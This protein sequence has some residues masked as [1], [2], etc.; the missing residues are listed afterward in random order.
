MLDFLHIENVAVIKKLDIEFG[1]GFNVLTGET[2]AGKSIIIDSINMLLGA[3]ATKEIIRHGEQ[4]AVVSAFFSNVSDDI[5]KLCDEYDIP[6]DREDAFSIYRSF[7][8]DGKNAVKINSYPATLTQ[9]RAIG[10]HLINIHGQNENQSFMNKSNHIRLLDEYADSE[11]LLL[12]YGALYSKLNSIKAEIGALIEENKQKDTMIDILNFQIKEISAAKLKDIN[13]E[14]KLVELRN[15]LKGAEKIIKGSQTVYK[16]LMQNESGISASV[17][18]TKAIDA[19]NKLSDVEGDAS[20]LCERLTGIKFEIEDIAERAK[21]YSSFEGVGDPQH[22]L[23]IVEDRLAVIQRLERKYGPDIE[24]VINF[25]NDAE[26]KL[27]NFENAENQILDLKDEYKK[28]YSSALDIAKNIHSNRQRFSV[29]LSKLVKEA[30]EFLDMPKVKFEI[31]VEELQKE[32]NPVLNS[33]GCDDVEFLIATNAGEESAPMCRIASGGEL[34]RIMLAMKSALSDKNGVET[35]I[36]DEIDT[37][38]SGSTSQKIGIKL[39][40]ISAN[41]QTFCVTHSAQIA[42]LAT[43]HFLIKKSEIGGRVETSINLLNDE[44]RISEIARII[45]GIDITDKQFDAARELINQSK[46]IIDDVR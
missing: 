13:E 31:K 3:K 4:R 10:A 44:E 16:A 20:E 32:Q 5:F 23:D 36:F 24:S 12:E 1:N 18:I 9:L 8:I 27:K 17:L 29:K 11:Q 7:G 22:Q 28:I 35:V 30:L 2:G 6:Y 41:T 15:R 34:A 45:G 38:V 43:N 40:K 21:E 33:T 14:E 26:I 19:L 39:A 37:G 42:S 46:V 25:K